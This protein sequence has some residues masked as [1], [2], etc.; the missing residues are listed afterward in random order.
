MIFENFKK[1]IKEKQKEYNDPKNQYYIRKDELKKNISYFISYVIF[2]DK[3]ALKEYKKIKKGKKYEQYIGEI[4]ENQNY[5]VL[6]NGIHEGLNDKKIDLI[7]INTKEILLIQCKNWKTNKYKITKDYVIKFL[8][9]CLKWIKEN[10]IKN[11]EWKA[12]IIMSK[13]LLDKEAYKFI[14]S[15][16]YIDYKI[17][18]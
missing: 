8:N 18:K 16:P 3:K 9:S 15:N 11:F 2:N 6:Y 4:Y 7:A 12:L 1:W 14:K 5:Q 17:I 13:P 10:E